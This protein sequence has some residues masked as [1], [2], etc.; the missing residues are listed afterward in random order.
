MTIQSDAAGN[1]A[2]II[3][4]LYIALAVEAKVIAFI[5]GRVK[6]YGSLLGL[7]CLAAYWLSG[8]V[9]MVNGVLALGGLAVSGPA[10]WV[11]L[12]CFAVAISSQV[13]I[14]IFAFRDHPE[15]KP[16]AE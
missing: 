13:V 8:V 6:S 11:D 9:L 2:A 14:L 16:S 15:K 3:A 1:A 10:A 12:V 4:T 5:T 7:T